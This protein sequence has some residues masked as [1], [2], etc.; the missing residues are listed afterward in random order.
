MCNLHVRQQAWGWH[1]GSQ[2]H[3]RKVQ[4][5]PYRA[6]RLPAED[7]ESETLDF[8]VIEVDSLER[9]P[10]VSQTIAISIPPSRSRAF[11]LRIQFESAFRK[12]KV[13]AFVPR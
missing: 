4:F 10:E 12:R 5:A 8:G 11:L 9:E 7:G 1:L 2:G 13:R 6:M 3:K